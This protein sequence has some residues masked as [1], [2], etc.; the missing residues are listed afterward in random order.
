LGFSFSNDYF[1]IIITLVHNILG[2][3]HE[4]DVYFCSCE[5]KSVTLIRHRLW[6]ASPCFPKIA[7]HFDFMEF[8]RSVRI[9]CHASVHSLCGSLAIRKHIVNGNVEVKQQTCIC[10]S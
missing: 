2:R 9:E 5:G 3:Q 1:V 10:I 4:A 7:F 8:I 6:P